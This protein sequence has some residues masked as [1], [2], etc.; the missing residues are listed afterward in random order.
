MPLLEGSTQTN[1]PIVSL[2]IEPAYSRVMS[3]DYLYTRHESRDADIV[4]HGFRHEIL[5]RNVHVS[6]G[7]GEIA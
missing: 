3:L 5:S 7:Q 4:W 2:N 6:S 1:L